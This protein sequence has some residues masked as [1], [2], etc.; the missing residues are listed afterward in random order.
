MGNNTVLGLFKR[1]SPSPLENGG[2]PETRGNQAERLIGS[3]VISSDRAAF[4]KL[5]SSADPDAFIGMQER[6]LTKL[7]GIETG[8]ENMANGLTIAD[9]DG[10]ILY[11]NPA[12][13]AMH[14]LTSAE[15]IG[16]DVRVLAPPRAHGRRISPE[17]RSEMREWTRESVNR[18]QRVDEE[19]RRVDEDFE[20][21]LRSNVLMHPDRDIPILIVTT[22][23][24]ISER[25]AAQRALEES[26]TK[27]RLLNETMNNGSIVLEAVYGE[28]GSV[29]DGIFIDINPAFARIAGIDREGSKGKRVSEVLPDVDEFIAELT[30]VVQTGKPKTF[31]KA[32]TLHDRHYKITAYQSS[33]GTCACHIEDITEQIKISR[34]LQHA[35]TQEALARLYNGILHDFNNMLFVIQ[36]SLEHLGYDI[37]QTGSDQVPAMQQ[38]I[39]TMMEGLQRATRLIRSLLDVS[40]HPEEMQ[41]PLNLQHHI[42][43]FMDEWRTVVPRMITLE[44]DLKP[45][46]MIVANPVEIDQLM[47]NLLTNAI[48]ALDN[49]TGTLRVA[50][51]ETVNDRSEMLV[52]LSVQ[53][54]GCG[55]AAEDRARI[56]EAY[57]SSSPRQYAA[58]HNEGDHH[59]TGLGLFTCTSIARN[60][61]AKINL[62]S[63]LGEGT[64][65][66]IAFPVMTD[67]DAYCPGIRLDE[68]SK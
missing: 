63:E 9:L 53:D 51:Q 29:V 14:G 32:H 36:A 17:E 6:D 10:N 47:L 8:V 18:R 50:L 68:V 1:K 52:E 34:S 46:P 3:N 67:S 58:E 54:T 56:F 15:L 35:E 30:E 48:T 7:L 4:L 21:E 40:K 60:H 24:D 62:E 5:F 57:Y 45:T 25:K 49:K 59:G 13:A 55:L 41:R 66:R 12:E 2:T 16:Q 37:E 61:N 28:D 11:V 27:Y 20:V 65:F 33:P 42:E 43:R 19:G 31:Q 38:Q 39:N 22:C 64:T 26:E 44:L 23:R